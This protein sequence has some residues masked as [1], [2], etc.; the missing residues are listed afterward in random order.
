MNDRNILIIKT[1]WSHVLSQPENPGYVFYNALFEMAPCLRHMFK[2][3]MD[4]QIVKLTDMITFMVSNLQNMAEIRP[5]IDALARRHAHYGVKPEHYKTVGDALI[6][7]MATISG[8]LWN[9]ETKQAW[10]DLYNTWAEEMI[11]AFDH[12]KQNSM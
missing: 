2:S 10:V 4:Q 1:S 7:T 11:T 9:D 8:S 6:R 12:E 5:E 3:D